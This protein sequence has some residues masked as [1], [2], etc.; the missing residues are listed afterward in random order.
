M[1]SRRF[2]FAKED[3]GCV[4]MT[5]FGLPCAC[6]LAEKRK[7]KFPILLDEIH[8]HWRRLC[9]IGEEVDVNFS[10]MEEWNAIQE[11]LKKDPYKMKVFIKEKLRGLGFSEDTMLKPPPRKVAIKGA[12]KRV[13]STPKTR[14][15]GQIPSRWET[16]D[17]QNPD[18][19]CSHGKSNVPKS[20]GDGN[21]GFRI[22]ARH[23]GLNEE[24][25]VLVRRALINELK[26][27]KTDYLPIYG[28]ERR[29]K[30]I[31]DGLHPPTSKGGIVPVEKWLTTQDM[32][33]I[34]ATCY[35]RAVVLL[36]LPKMGCSCETYFP[37]RSAPPLKSHSN[38]ICLFLIPDHFLHAKLKEDCVLPPP[39][40]KWMTHKIDEVE[41]WHFEFMDRQAVF[42]DLMSKELKLPR[43]PT[44]EHNPITYD[45]PTPKKSKQD[46]EVM[47][48]D[49]D[50]ALS[51]V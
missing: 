48:E 30:L 42:D 36:T 22:I 44:N 28:T 9:V 40:K 49:E 43:K 51:L 13:K 3:Y 19:Q 45:T 38:I 31:L 7:K 5:T 35:N 34:I 14:S 32:G 24:D 17:S 33:H 27:H 1:H 10:V 23:M 11:R 46:F 50:Y 39:C 2:D 16:I 21:C 8:P 37:I 47:D 15:T 20:K 12:P 25:H 41:K 6:I 29:Y 18:S 4:Q 26:N